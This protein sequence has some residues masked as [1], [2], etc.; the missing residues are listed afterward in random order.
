[1]IREPIYVVMEGRAVG[2]RE[3][4]K[5]QPDPIDRD[6]PDDPRGNIRPIAVVFAILRD[7]PDSIRPIT[8]GETPEKREGD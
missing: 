7:D 3:S 5:A 8:A 6:E 1:L 2:D 4:R